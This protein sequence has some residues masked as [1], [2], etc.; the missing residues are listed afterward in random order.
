MSLLQKALVSN[1]AFSV[2][3][4]LILS[5]FSNQFSEWFQTDNKTPFFVI[6]LLLLGFSLLV[7]IEFNKQ[8]PFWIKI[9]IAQDIAWVLVSAVLV[10]FNPLSISLLG[11]VIV[12]LVAIIVAF[13]AFFQWKGLYL[14]SA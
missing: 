3:S 11:N 4:G 7:F 13:F 1:A 5:F 2:C 10:V 14:Q 12:F 8:R 9:I 6:G